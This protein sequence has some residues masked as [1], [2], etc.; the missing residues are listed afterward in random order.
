MVLVLELEFRRGDIL[1]LFA[2]MKR[3]QLRAESAYVAWVSTIRRDRRVD[4]GSNPAY[5]MKKRRGRATMY[6]P[7]SGRRNS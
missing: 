6:F 4:E 2:K 3:D 7:D 5:G 1:N